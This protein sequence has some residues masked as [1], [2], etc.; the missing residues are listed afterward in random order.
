MDRHDRGVMARP[1]LRP[2]K[3]AEVDIANTWDE[4][5]TRC[6]KYVHMSKEVPKGSAENC[7]KCFVV[8]G[9]MSMVLC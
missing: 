1:M 2:S 6:E 3:G 4:D 9:I 5:D 7:T 8:L